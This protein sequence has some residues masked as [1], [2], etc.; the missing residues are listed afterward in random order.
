V[1]LARQ[2]FSGD[3]SAKTEFIFSGNK[4]IM[5]CKQIL[6]RLWRKKPFDFELF[7]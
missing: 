3:G 6:W 5:P 2:H 7:I 1:R 4:F